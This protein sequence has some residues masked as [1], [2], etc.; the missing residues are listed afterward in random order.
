[1]SRTC[2]V[3]PTERFVTSRTASSIMSPG[4]HCTERV[5]R[6][7]SRMPPSLTTPVASPAR[8]IGISMSIFLDMSIS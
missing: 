2:R 6:T 4:R 5:R 8:R 3:L 1:M 7:C